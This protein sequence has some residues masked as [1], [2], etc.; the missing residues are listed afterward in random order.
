MDDMINDMI[1][2]CSGKVGGGPSSPIK[3]I[4]SRH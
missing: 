4:I 1:S 2:G 3:K